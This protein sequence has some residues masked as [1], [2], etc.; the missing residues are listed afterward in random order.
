MRK[1]AFVVLL[2]SAC[3]GTD[4]AKNTTTTVTNVG[5]Q[6][7]I[8]TGAMQATFG[9]GDE[10]QARLTLKSSGD[11][12]L[13]GTFYEPPSRYFA[14]GRWN[15]DGDRIAIEFA[16]APAQR[17]VFERSGPQLTPREW[18]RSVWGEKGPPVLY[19]LMRP[20]FTE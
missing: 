6:D 19:R 20:T 5:A 7:G 14:E 11:A 16:G 15:A 9:G 12:S 1:A 8:Y 2:V 10:R 3:G 4:P 13:Q 17:V 18:D